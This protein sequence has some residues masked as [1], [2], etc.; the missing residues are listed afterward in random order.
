[1]VASLRGRMVLVFGSMLITVLLLAVL[2]VWGSRKA[3]L[4]LRRS[5]LADSQLEAYLSFA[6]D[7]QRLY[8]QVIEQPP[9]RGQIVNTAIPA[10]LAQ[11]NDHINRL[12]ALVRQEVELAFDAADA[13]R[14]QAELERVATLRQLI[15]ELGRVLEAIATITNPGLQ[16][17]RWQTL[18]LSL[19]ELLNG[20]FRQQIDSAIADERAEA[21]AVA[22]RSRKLTQWLMLSAAGAAAG[23]V[24]LTLLVGLLLLRGVKRPI[25]TLLAG[26]DRLAGGDFQ[27]KIRL[28]SP[29]EFARLAAGCNHMST[30]LQRQRQALLDAHSELERKVEERTRE[31]HHA[32]QRLQQ[33][34][35]TRRQFFADISHE[36]RTPLTALRGEAE[37]SLRGAD[38]PVAEY[39]AVLRRIARLSAQM[40]RLVDDLLLLARSDSLQTRAEVETLSLDDLLAEV[41]GNARALAEREGLTLSLALSD[42]N[43]F[44]RGD[45]ERLR[46]ALLGLIDNACRY[47]PVPG[48]VM[49][50][51]ERDGETAVLTVSDTGIGIDPDEQAAV[52]ERYFRGRRATALVPDGNGLGLA[53]VQAIAQDHHGALNLASTPGVGTTVTLRLP[54][55]GSEARIDAFAAG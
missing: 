19:T 39:Q 31:L 2:S 17:R 51:L 55:S 15:S 20:E 25:D 50:S 13:M 5:Q 9:P 45:R 16:P 28:L 29:Q 8:K 48:E 52:F 43:L 24:L 10:G 12:E 42:H 33:L 22:E 53:L 40:G 21:A 11:L 4:Y 1:M 18:L 30:Q 37:V 36:L 6:L 47:T 32:N 49:L 38:K 54:L 3:D 26:I 46:Q 14:E 23:A 7:A 27:H 44:L 35:Q 41:C 34:D